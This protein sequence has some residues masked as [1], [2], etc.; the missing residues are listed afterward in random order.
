MKTNKTVSRIV[1]GMG[2][3]FVLATTALL[4][5]T[6]R[7]AEPMK[8]MKGGEHLVMLTH[9]NTQAQ[10]EELKP[11]D[12]IA[13]VC[14][15]C[16]SV[17]VHNVTTEKGHIKI[18]TVGEKHLCPGC[19]STITTVGTGKGPKGAH[20]EV[21]HVCEKCGSESVFCCATK[22]GSKPTEGMDKK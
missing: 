17:M 7:A 12:S 15:V 14:S 3:A 4:P 8:P 9:L 20:N 5:V 22:P 16:K 6:A 19:N 2:A 1:F 21:K 10:A 18:M 13:M 11:G